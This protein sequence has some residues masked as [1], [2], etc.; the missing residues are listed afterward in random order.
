MEKNK[1]EKTNHNK[2]LFWM[3]VLL[4]LTSMMLVTSSYAWFTSN[5][6][7]S[8]DSLNVHVQAQGG[9]EISVDGSAW[10]TIVTQDDLINAVSTYSGSINQLPDKLEPVSTGGIVSGGFLNMYYGITSN[11]ESGNYILSATKSN[12][13][14]GN[15]TDSD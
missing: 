1:K 15:G 6:I 11:D 14:L 2:R 10:K 12:E 13:T 4:L 8:V 3:F 9:I 7:V 5:R